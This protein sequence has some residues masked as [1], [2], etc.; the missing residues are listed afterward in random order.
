MDKQTTLAK[1]AKSKLKKGIV[2]F[3]DKSKI[4]DLPWD[5]EKMPNVVSFYKSDLGSKIADYTLT[6]RT[7]DCGMVKVSLFRK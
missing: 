6:V 5:T 4:E 3:S 2:T 7:T 1:A